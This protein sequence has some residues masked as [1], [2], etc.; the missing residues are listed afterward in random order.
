MVN[1]LGFDSCGV[2]QA[3]VLEEYRTPLTA[4]ISKGMHGE[5]AYMERNQEKRIDPCQLVPG[6]KSVVSVLLNYYPGNPKICVGAPK[7]SRYALSIDYHKVIKDLLWRLLDMMRSEFGPI[8]GR[9]FVD[10]APVLE[11]A[12]A[13]RAGLGWVGKN[14]MLINPNIGSYTFIGELIVDADIEP[15]KPDVPNRCGTCTRCM[16]A[17]PTGAIESPGVV[18]ARRCIAY[19]TIEKKSSLSEQEVSSLNGWCFGCDICQEVCPWNSKAKLVTLP[20]LQPKAEILAL[21]KES[22][23]SVTTGQ[24]NSLFGNTPIIRKGYMGF[25]QRCRIGI[26]Q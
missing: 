13:Q 2:S 25:M 19:L 10:S 11:R 12:W 14:G 5:M 23:L 20:D 3:Q 21:T 15:S 1:A 16:D 17:C 6:A 18:D 9:A 24:F 8:S 22:L 4:W 26:N 7:I